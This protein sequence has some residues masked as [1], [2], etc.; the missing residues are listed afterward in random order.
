MITFPDIKP[1]S[2]PI[3]MTVE[4][5]SIRS[6]FEDGSMQS[7]VKFTR[8]RAKYTLKWNSLP[9]AEYDVLY[10]FITETVKYSAQ[11]FMWTNP[12][13]K[14]TLEVRIT[15]VSGAEL[16]TLAFWTITLE[17]TEV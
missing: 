4:D 9:Q 12:A 11:S 16:K 17:L 3:G 5:N 2:Y 14:K 10:K 8:S 6:N 15:N 1:P 7:R 13:T